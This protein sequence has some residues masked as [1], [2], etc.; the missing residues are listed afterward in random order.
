M[1]HHTIAGNIYIAISNHHGDVN[2]YLTGSAIYK[3]NKLTDKFA[4]YQ[5]LP[6][7][8]PSGFEF[9]SIA[10]KH[11]LAVSNNY[12]GKY[13][14]DSVIYQWNGKRFVVFQKIRTN[15]A[16]K[17]SF[18][19]IEGE[20]YLAVANSY[21]G[22]THSINSVVYQWKNN[23][24]HKFQEIGTEGAYGC[25][26][27][28]IKSNA[29]IAFGNYYNSKQKYSVQST[30]FKW[31]GGHFVKFQSLQTYGAPRCEVLQRESSHIP[32]FCQ[33]LL[34]KQPQHRLLHFTSGMV[35]SS[36][37]SSPF[38]HEVV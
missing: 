3:L 32:R 5:T 11:F 20:N 31:S 10:D 38:L 29:F 13:K 27:F 6:T 33:L 24:F 25:L 34:W 4:L 19:D 22:S 21:D 1:K 36:F 7:K 37:C 28:K 26:A 15:G 35:T 23:Q 12:Y 18:V 8:G 2:K 17:F 30:V 9:F 16:R 14:L